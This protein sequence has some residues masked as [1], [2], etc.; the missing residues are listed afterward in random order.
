MTDMTEIGMSETGMSEIREHMAVMDADGNQI[1]T[2]DGVEGD[3]IKLTRDSSPD[4][5]HTYLMADHIDMVSEDGVMLVVGAMPEMSEYGD[6]E[7]D[8]IEAQDNGEAPM[9]MGS[10]SGTSGL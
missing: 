5:E 6:D 10:G 8:D 3:R 4:G 7:A 1:G 9:S 2:V